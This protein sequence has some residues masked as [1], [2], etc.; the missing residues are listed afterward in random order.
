MHEGQQSFVP[1]SR[2]HTHYSPFMP[3]EQERVCAADSCA[4]ALHRKRFPLLEGPQD[5]FEDQFLQ[6]NQNSKQA[7]L[8]LQ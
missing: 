3:T 6:A 1:I 2:L 5:S 8:K 7:V 4:P